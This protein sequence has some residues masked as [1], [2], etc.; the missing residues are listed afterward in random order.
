MNLNVHQAM[1]KKQLCHPGKLNI[2]YGAV[3]EQY[4]SCTFEMLRVS[5]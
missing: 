5:F 2:A 4:Y 3:V 1:K